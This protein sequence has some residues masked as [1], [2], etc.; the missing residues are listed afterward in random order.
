MVYEN[1][2]MNKYGNEV[3]INI[4]VQN[5]IR[6]TKYVVVMPLICPFRSHH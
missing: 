3:R 4:K 5:N 1:Y 2:K 6:N